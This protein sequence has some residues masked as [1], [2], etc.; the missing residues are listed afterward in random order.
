M[1]PVVVMAAHSHNYAPFSSFHNKVRNNRALN[2]TLLELSNTTG[3]A[4]T[5]YAEKIG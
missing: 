3:H 2:T 1:I 4:H 5:Q